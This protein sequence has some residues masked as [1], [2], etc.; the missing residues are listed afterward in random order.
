VAFADAGLDSLALVALVVDL[1][2]TFAV[3]FPAELMNADTFQTPRSV[4]EAMRA[5]RG[6]V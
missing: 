6:A 2:Q 4:A 5:L 1:E 3:Q